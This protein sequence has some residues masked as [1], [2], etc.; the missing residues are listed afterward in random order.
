MGGLYDWSTEQ[1]VPEPERVQSH[2]EAAM[3]TNMKGLKF[4]GKVAVMG[5]IL[6]NPNVIQATLL[7][8]GLCSALYL[9]GAAHKAYGKRHPIY[10][11]C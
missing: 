10:S 2:I 4:A 7:F 8:G 11:I 6:E 5:V 9:T 1:T 3:P